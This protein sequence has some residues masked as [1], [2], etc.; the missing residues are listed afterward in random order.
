MKGRGGSTKQ[1]HAGWLGQVQGGELAHPTAAHPAMASPLSSHT[2]T[3]QMDRSKWV[4][5]V[6]LLSPQHLAK[7]RGGW[8]G[9]WVRELHSFGAAAWLPRQQRKGLPT[10]QPAW[11]TSACLSRRCRGSCRGLQGC[12]GRGRSSLRV[13]WGWG[14][15]AWQ[16]RCARMPLLSILLPPSLAPK[17]SPKETP[18]HSC[19]RCA[20]RQW[21]PGACTL[22]S[23][24]TSCRTRR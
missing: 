18:T 12:V 6:P 13:G 17:T 3:H 21:R 15:K 1:A 10:V 22:R 4:P 19:P 16:V 8:A 20:R 5:W 24:R 11:L 7:G 14:V 2:S 23:G 9:G